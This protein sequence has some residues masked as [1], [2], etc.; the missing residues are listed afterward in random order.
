MLIRILSILVIIILGSCS[1]LPKGY[2][3]SKFSVNEKNYNKYILNRTPDYGDSHLDGCIIMK[4]IS[5]QLLSSDGKLINGYIKDVQSKEPL[6]YA[7]IEI[8]LDGQINPL[9][10][11]SDSKGHFKFNKNSKI[12]SINTSSLGYRTL[13]IKIEGETL[14]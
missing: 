10:L 8:Y 7:S 3:L 14:F 11:A 4:E 1:T 5:L 2:K 12:N 9:K 6:E 13:F